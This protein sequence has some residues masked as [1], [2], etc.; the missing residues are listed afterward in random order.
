VHLQLNKNFFPRPGG[1]PAPSGH[2]EYA[3]VLTCSCRFSSS[4][5]TR[6]FPYFRF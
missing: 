4:P 3:C 5:R 2:P 1:A 6:E